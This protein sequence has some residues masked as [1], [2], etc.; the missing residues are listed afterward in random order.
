MA[1]IDHC[2][3]VSIFY[4]FGPYPVDVIGSDRSV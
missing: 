2:V 4:W 1:L 3:I